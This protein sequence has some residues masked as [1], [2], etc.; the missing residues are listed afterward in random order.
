MA[1]T[2]Y[3]EYSVD[4]EIEAFKKS[5]AN[6]AA[7]DAKARE[8]AGDTIVP[9]MSRAYAANSVYAGPELEYVVQFRLETLAPKAEVTSQMNDAYGSLVT[10]VS[11]EGK[12]GEGEGGPLRV[13]LMSRVRGVTHLDFILAH[14]F[15][16]IY[17]RSFVRH[18]NLID[19]VAQYVFTQFPSSHPQDQMLKLFAASWLY[20][21]KHLGESD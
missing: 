17:R 5:S 9:S 18:E 8:L 1:T 10:L 3:P 4:A 16:E 6:R 20:L 12:V 7:C 2:T 19:D 15:A 14:G 21:G 11:F 13:Y